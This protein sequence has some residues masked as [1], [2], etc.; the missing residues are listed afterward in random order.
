MTT[1]EATAEVFWRR[2]ALCLSSSNWRSSLVGLGT[3]S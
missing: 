2:S 3:G 1:K